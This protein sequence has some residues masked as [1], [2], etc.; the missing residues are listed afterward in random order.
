MNL[1]MVYQSDPFADNQGGGV[2]YV[3]NILNGI[4]SSFKSILFLGVGKEEIKKHNVNF[5]P[6]TSKITNYLIYILKMTIIISKIDTRDYDIVHVHRLYFAI[7][8]MLLKPGLKIVCTLHGRTFSVFESIYGTS[9]L[10][11]FTPLFMLIE[12]YSIKKIHYLVPVSKDVIDSFEGRYPGFSAKK[13]LSIAS[14]VLDLTKYSMFDE[15]ASKTELG[16]DTAYNYLGF[17][18]RLS[19]VKDVEFLIKTCCSGIEYFRKN[20]IK[21][22]IIGGG[23]EFNRLKNMISENN[24]ENYAILFG[25]VKPDSIDLALS[26]M[27]MLLICSKHESGPIVM[28]ESLQC[29]IPVVS[30]DVGEV[31][32]YIVNNRN[33]FIVKK[34]KAEYLE[35]IERIIDKPFS[36]EGVL[37]YSA[38]SLERSS[39][40]TVSNIY[41]NIYKKLSKNGI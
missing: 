8:F 6:I 2:R 9:I 19:F 27:R 16:L 26:A 35:K 17:I 12:K 40:A 4:S 7:P 41:I 24:L 37:H 1:I 5:I 22:L 38:I 3:N 15:E 39:I 33:G 30:N 14:P 20:R 31:K 21:L 13:N 28:K 23:E 34:D 32:N 25:V 11:M 36:K 10:K 18:G 29:G